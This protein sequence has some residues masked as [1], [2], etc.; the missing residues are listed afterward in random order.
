MTLDLS[1]SVSA[2]MNLSMDVLEN[3]DLSRQHVTKL[4]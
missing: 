3:N 1:Y 4:S 2:Y